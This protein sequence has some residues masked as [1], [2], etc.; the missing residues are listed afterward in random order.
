M[1]RTGPKQYYGVSVS[2]S[3]KHRNAF[4]D[5]LLHEAIQVFMDVC[6]HSFILSIVLIKY[7]SWTRVLKTEIFVLGLS[8]KYFL[9]KW[10]LS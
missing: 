6:F 2:P 9:R 1:W 4:T 10:S 3:D 8:G 7:L 5:I